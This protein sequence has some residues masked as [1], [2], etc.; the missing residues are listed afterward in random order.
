MATIDAAAEL[1]DREVWQKGLSAPPGIARL[2]SQCEAF[3]AYLERGVFS[4]GC[5]FVAAAAEL[6][7]KPGPVRDHFLAKYAGL[8]EG[9]ARVAHEAQQMGEIDASEDVT[10]LIFELD[11]FMLG[12][13][14][15]YVFFADPASLDRARRAVRRRLELARGPAAPQ[16]F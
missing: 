4:G 12:A 16:V 5:F 7:A 2:L 15:A 9:F 6:D 10:Q 14:F 11:A 13:N 8:L 1:F 3:F